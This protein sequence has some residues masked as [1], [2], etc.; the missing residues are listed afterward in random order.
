MYGRGYGPPGGGYGGGGGYG[1]SLGGYGPPPSGPG[2]YGGAPPSGPRHHA[3]LGSRGAPSN[4]PPP[5]NLAG[6]PGGYGSP[7]VGGAAGALGMQGAAGEKFSLFVGSIVDGLENGWLESILGVAGPVLSFRRP[8]PPFAFVEY[9]EAESVLR[10]LEVVNGAAIKMPNGAE[11]TLLVKADE[12][13][14]GRLDEYEKDRVKSEENDDL[15][16]QAKDDL[17]NILRR[18]AAGDPISGTEPEEHDSERKPHIPQHLKDLAPEDLP[19]SHRNNTLSSIAQFREAAVKKAHQRFELDRQIEERRQAMIAQN[20]RQHQQRAAPAYSP[21]GPAAGPSHAMPAASQDPQSFNRPVP[22]V[23]GGAGANGAPV[24]QAEPELDDM[25]RERERAEAEHR[26]QEAVYRNRERQFEQRERARIAA[27]EREQA[28]EQG[29]AEQEERD[30]AYMAERLATWDD[31][32]EAERGR[33]LFYIDRIRWRAQRKPHRLR[34][35]EADAR[36][37]AVEAQQ[38][39]ALNEQSDSFLSQ[40]ADLFP[41][42]LPTPDTPA[43]GADTASATPGGATPAVGVKLNLTTAPKPVVKEAPK[44]RPTAMALA[45]EEE[46]GRKKREL[47]PLE[48]SD[49]EDEAQPRPRLSRSEMERKA[50]EI[51]AKVPTSKDGLWTW[52]VRWKRLNDDIIKRRITP[53][54]NRLIVDYLGGEEAELLNVVNEYLRDH[55]G[56]QALLEELEPVLDEDVTN[57]VVKV[58]RRLA[59]ETEFEHAGI[60]F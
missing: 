50:R 2:G 48:Y 54:A 45:D 36:D 20:A 22:F 59:I 51:E 6:S 16:Q 25:E 8:S 49:D 43:S 19:E 41:S 33:E 57:F 47:I 23:A 24:P 7:P 13:T 40:H 3:G 17:A 27:W 29:I 38:L 58:W 44:P 14:R 28:R 18:I 11:K 53:Y 15:T 30:R 9:A 4:L 5:P 34:E 60:D 37:R 46:E 39:A 10:C 26:Q 35:Q 42:S 1:R 32:R 52:K 12:K 31:D 55:K 56:P 21:P